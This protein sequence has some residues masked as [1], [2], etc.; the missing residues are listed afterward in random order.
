MSDSQIPDYNKSW[1]PK[2]RAHTEYKSITTNHRSI[3]GGSFSVVNHYCVD[4]HGKVGNPTQLESDAFRGTI[5]IV[6]GAIGLALLFMMAPEFDES[7]PK[8]K[9]SKIVKAILVGAICFWIYSC[10]S[11]IMLLLKWKKWAKERGWKVGS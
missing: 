6:G 1:C 8:E 3:E 11:S 7:L 5:C 4:C 9:A 10:G 2:C